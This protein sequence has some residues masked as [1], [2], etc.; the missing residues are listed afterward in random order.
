MPKDEKTNAEKIKPVLGR[1]LAGPPFTKAEAEAIVEMRIQ[2]GWSPFELHRRVNAQNPISRAHFNHLLQ[3]N[4]ERRRL[5]KENRPAFAKAFEWPEGRYDEFPLGCMD[6]FLCMLPVSPKYFVGRKTELKYLDQ[7]WQSKDVQ[8]VSLVAQ[9]GTGKT[10]LVN[11]WLNRMRERRWDGARRVYAWSFYSQGNAGPAQTSAEPFFNHA[12]ERFGAKDFKEKFPWEKGVAL[13]QLLQRERVLL[14]L[15]GI[16]RLQHSPS[17]LQGRLRDE[18]MQSLLRQLARS[19]H[20]GMCVITT[21]WPVGDL[22]RQPGAV[23]PEFHNL[24]RSDG[25]QLLWQLGA[26]KWAA[27][28]LVPESTELQ[29]VSDEFKGHPLALTLLARFIAV[30]HDGDIRK[31]SLI[32]PLQEMPELEG[33]QAARIMRS[34]ERI[35]QGKPELEILQLL[36]LFDRP[37][38][39][40]PLEVLLR[41]PTI[42]GI[43]GKVGQFNGP[44]W[45]FA[46]ESLRAL[47]LVDPELPSQPGVLDCHPLVREHFGGR[48]KRE[49]ESGWKQCH[50]RLYRHFKQWSGEAKPE[51]WEQIEPLYR[52][53]GH[54]CKAGCYQD[55]FDKVYIPLIAQDDRYYSIKVLG[56]FTADLEAMSGFFADLQNGPDQ[57]GNPV[58]DLNPKSKA[59]VLGIVGW[60]LRSL[61]RLREAKRVTLAAL[62]HFKNQESTPDNFIDCAINAANLSELSLLLGEVQASVSFAQ[63]CVTFADKSGDIRQKSVK[64][65]RLADSLHQA[66]K[67][68]EAECFFNEAESLYH[69]FKSEQKYISSWPGFW[70]CDLLLTLSRTDEVLTRSTYT[71]KIG[72]KLQSPSDVGL[73]YLSMA[74]AQMQNKDI[75]SS[76]VLRNFKRATKNLRD[77]KI[78]EFLVRALLGYAELARLLHWREGG[79]KNGKRK[80][81]MREREGQI[82][83]R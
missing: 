1:T 63:E 77:S 31:R 69:E 75:A 68:A 29:N 23:M 78:G 59:L 57:W 56:A 11:E 28:H 58:P 20:P 32:P 27:H 37:A 53:M 12:L 79:R 18:G 40:G 67:F 71:L 15:D 81:E 45:K 64:R 73:N 14:I 34:Y 48:L 39:A 9:G 26:N 42:R 16:E 50:R 8:I 76:T 46:I 80:V 5:A 30:L 35:L 52:A 17:S 65:A 55:A 25:A 3:I 33:G 13:A 10:S 19:G 61:G 44:R 38:E 62:D 72:K 4:G 74:I 60:E 43:T 82:Q 66:G 24:H 83:D 22:F 51:K 2:R 47:R 54:G 7:V 36:G 41:K 70:F 6:E 21:R 49:S